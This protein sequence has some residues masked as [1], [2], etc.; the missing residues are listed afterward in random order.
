M[1]GK[2]R[3]P[4]V[5]ASVASGCER[6]V[7]TVSGCPGIKGKFCGHHCYLSSLT[8]L[9]ETLVSTRDWA[10]KRPEIK[11]TEGVEIPDF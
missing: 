11:G 2:G 10:F 4:A 7:M 5:G 6:E 8:S 1:V 3:L 9:S